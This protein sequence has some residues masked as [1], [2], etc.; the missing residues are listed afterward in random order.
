ML[1]AIKEKITRH[2]RKKSYRR[3]TNERMSFLQKRS[4][5]NGEKVAN[6]LLYADD[7]SQWYYAV[8]GKKLNLDSPKTLNEKI[9]WLKINDCTPAKTLF[10]DKYLVKR[11]LEERIGPGYTAKLFGVWDSFSDID[12]TALPDQFALKINHGFAGNLFVMDKKHFDFQ[13]AQRKF[14]RW[15]NRDYAFQDGFE[16]HYS[17]IPPKILG[18]EYLGAAT[19]LFYYRFF[20]FNGI[21]QML[22]IGRFIREKKGEYAFYDLD[23]NRLPQLLADRVMRQP[24]KKTGN[25]EELVRLAEAL[26]RDFLFV[27][28][29]FYEIKGRIYFSEM[30]F[31]PGSGILKWSKPEHNLYYGK[32][33][34]LP[35]D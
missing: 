9:Q 34:K 33:L 19:D 11:H 27:R 26:C 8:T 5:N 17:A 30:T 16:L 12:F 1:N 23:H 4:E 13:D 7:L 14:E 15:L 6:P 3:T 35:I 29:D 21:P 28:V 10:S 18:E 25:F 32:L 24:L 2:Y 22:R 31:T 20:C